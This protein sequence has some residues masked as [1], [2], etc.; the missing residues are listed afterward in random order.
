MHTFHFV[1]VDQSGGQ[2][3]LPG[4]GSQVSLW[5]LGIDSGGGAC[6]AGSLPAEL[7]H[8]LCISFEDYQ[9]NL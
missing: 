9:L 2:K 7:S 3:E 4:T 5:D 6:K 8:W 1:Y